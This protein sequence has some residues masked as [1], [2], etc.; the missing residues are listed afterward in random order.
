MTS[1]ALPEILFWPLVIAGTA[2]LAYLLY[3]LVEK[4]ETIKDWVVQVTR[5]R[6]KLFICFL[7]ILGI[8]LLALLIW[9]YC[10]WWILQD[11]LSSDQ[12]VQ[13]HLEAVKTV[14]TILG[15]LLLIYGIFLTAKRVRA[16]EN[17][18]EISEEEQVTERFTRAIE[19]LGSDKMEVRLGGIYA[20][21]RISKDSNKDYWTIMEVL[22]A[23]I[24]EN[25][26]WHLKEK[27]S[28]PTA[29]TEGESLE[30]WGQQN[31]EPPHP[32]PAT[33]I[34]AVLT[35]LKRRAC[36]FDR[37]EDY[38]LDLHKSDLS[39]ANLVGA[40]FERANFSE[41]SLKWADL[42]LAQLKKAIFYRAYLEG[43]ILWEAN[44][45]MAN[46]G[47]ANLEGAE[48]DAANL[49]WADL[50]KANLKGAVLYE[51]YLENAGLGRA[52]LEQADLRESSGLTPEQINNAIIDEHTLLPEY[53]E[54]DTFGRV[55]WA[56]PTLG[57]GANELEPP[58]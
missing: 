57:E 19:Q 8:P 55:R 53:L 25:A 30:E 17:Q 43:A 7:F 37:G 52:H 31:R 41:A 29:V 48:L 1:A 47:E 58:A 33:D 50:S 34:Q 36:H 22:T 6:N 51:T 3:I 26:P 24:R 32:K 12:K 38:P 45:E 44:L 9:H 14:A 49:R 15:G 27:K 21:E 2:L 46:L 20:L 54:R 13:G 40:H 16:L 23:F 18:V 4:L 11:G 56:S 39:G 5:D 28:L 10:N 42:E 35:V